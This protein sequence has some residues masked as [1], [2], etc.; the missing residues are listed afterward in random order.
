MFSIQEGSGACTDWPA[1]VRLVPL[2]GFPCHCPYLRFFAACSL[3]RPL[4]P[5]PSPALLLSVPASPHRSR[6]GRH[7]V[8]VHGVGSCRS[9][10]LRSASTTSL[11]PLLRSLCT[12]FTAPCALLLG[13]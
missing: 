1:T 7:S 6:A 8:A 12:S 3:G 5:P 4:L 13:R 10:L 11:Y 2:A 9:S